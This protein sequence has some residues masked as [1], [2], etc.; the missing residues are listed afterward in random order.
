MSFSWFPGHMAKG[1]RQIGEDLRLV[2]LVLLLVDA[3]IPRSSRHTQIESM[4]RRR[5]KAY[6]L[7]MNK[8][9]LA[10]TEATQQWAQHFRHEGLNVVAASALQGKGLDAIKRVVEKVRDRVLEKARRKGRI[11]APVRLL[12]AGIPNVGK[13]SLINRLTTQT[14]DTRGRSAP[15]K[16]GKQPGVTRAR[17][18]IALPGGLELRDSPG[19][20]FPRISS[21]QMFLHLA[22]T[23]AIKEDNLPLDRVGEE[24][25]RY[26][27]MKGRIDVTPREGETLLDAV[28]RARGMLMSGGV[29]DWERAAHFLLKQ[30]REAR[31]GPLTFEKVDDVV[32]APVDDKEEDD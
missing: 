4:L 20:L 26:L 15:A 6:V 19:I 32:D 16:T 28:A 30:T 25:A 14:G 11:D 10:E 7:V 13:S 9:D 1:L 29:P 12:V 23:G 22:A 8:T 21:E 17:Q 18:W 31:W 24:L 27:Q 2:D 3:R 5:D